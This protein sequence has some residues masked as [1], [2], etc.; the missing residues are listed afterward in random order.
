MITDHN[1]KLCISQH[2]F[3]DFTDHNMKLCISQHQFSDLRC[4]YCSESKPMFCQTLSV[5]YPLYVSVRFLGLVFSL[6]MICYFFL[7]LSLLIL[8]NLNLLIFSLIEFASSL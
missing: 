8:P 3:S 4:Y 6:S 7:R 2:Q 1:M 5:N